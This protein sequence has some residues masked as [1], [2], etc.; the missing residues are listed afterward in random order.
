MARVPPSA[1]VASLRRED[2]DRLYRA[3]QSALESAIAKG[4][5]H[6]ATSSRPGIPVA[7]ARAAAPR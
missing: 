5:V 1:R 3:L 6:P 7:R 4:G 2:V